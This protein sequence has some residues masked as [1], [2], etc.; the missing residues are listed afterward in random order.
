MGILAIGVSLALLMFLAYRGITVLL[1]AP[2]MAA[3]AVVLSGELALLLP[4]YTETFMPALGGYVLS[5]LPV[6][7]LGALFG[8][9]MADS[10]AAYTLSRWIL[11]V[12]GQRHAVLVIVV[13]C[14]L[15]TY[16]GVSLFVVAFA[17][18]PIAKDLFRSA[19]IPKRLIPA[20]IA[21][22]SFTFTMTA[23]PGTPAIQNAIPIPYFGT[24]AFAAPGLGL[25][26]SAIILLGG[27]W[28]LH[29][30]VAAAR[31]AGEGFGEHRVA[32]LEESSALQPADAQAT[33]EMPVFLALLPL[34]LVVAVNAVFTF[35]VFPS[36]D[37]SFLTPS[38]PAFNPSGRVGLWALIIALTVACATLML[39]RLGHW[40]D[41]KA[42]VNKGVFGFML[43]LFNTASEVGYG[44]VIAS[45]AGF[46][47][48][49]DAVLNLAPGNPLISEAIAMN[50]LSGITGS[51]S[52]GLSIALQALGADYLAMAEAAGISPDLLHRV[53]V[54]AAGGMDTLPHCGAIIT[55]LAICKLTHR[56][57]YLNIAA[58]TMLFP[59]LALVAVI[60][61]GTLFGSF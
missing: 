45:L 6:F 12:I 39:V 57:S 46:L 59:L 10:G 25:I 13:A 26:G 5:F 11:R 28:W 9:L 43:P 60:V 22:G 17:I 54:M 20:A 16:G 37:W 4:Y 49:R 44:A 29:T 40:T 8:Q 42:S 34:V 35:A 24:N 18:Y 32:E 58:V 55:L 38:Y 53:A 14:A 50:V 21:L 19:N 47:V 2:L 7:L 51:S 27:L 33:R 3:L 1:L 48:I 15:L 56:Q 23:M 61:L 30:R 41:L 52:G 31:A 36:M